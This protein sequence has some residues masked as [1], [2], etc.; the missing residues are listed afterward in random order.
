MQREAD[1]VL[2]QDEGLDDDLA[3][4][5]RDRLEHAPEE[6]LAVLQQLDAVAVPASP[7]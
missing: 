6:L 1:L 3:L 2:E 5:L 7:S 4:R